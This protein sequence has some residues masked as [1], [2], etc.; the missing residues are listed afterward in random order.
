MSTAAAVL[1]CAGSAV[2]A[3]AA[4]IAVVADCSTRDG[5]MCI[6]SHDAVIA[7]DLHTAVGSYLTCAVFVGSIID[8]NLTIPS[9]TQRCYWYQSVIPSLR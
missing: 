7:V 8:C 3:A 6:A 4:V 9:H 1:I 2:A 5:F